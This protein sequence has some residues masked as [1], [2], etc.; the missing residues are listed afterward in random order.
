M[1]YRELKI[2]KDHELQTWLVYLYELKSNATELNYFAIPNGFIG[3]MLNIEGET[4]LEQEEIKTPK[5]AV[6]GMLTKPLKVKH[7]VNSWELCLVFNP[8]FL[9][10]LLKDKMVHF[11]STTFCELIDFIPYSEV[12]LLR[13]KIA[14]SKSD[15]ELI[16][17][18][19]DFL[20]PFFRD[21]VVNTNALELYRLIHSNKALNVSE[22]SA[23][24]NVSPTTIRNWSTEHIGLSPKELIQIKRFNRILTAQDIKS[25]LDFAYELNY[26][27]QAHFIHFFKEKSGMKPSEY[28]KNKKFTFDFYNFKRWEI[29]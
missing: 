26:Y 29:D 3:I 25:A 24:F 10:L 9:Q 1:H 4:Y 11:T 17:L 18:L 27:D 15:A 12:E 16:E 22:L 8:V 28:F 19:T 20:R 23:Y 5:S 14:H 2:P 7:S 21:K 13:E 6:G